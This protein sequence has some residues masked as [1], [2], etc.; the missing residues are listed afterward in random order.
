MRYDGMIRTSFGFEG[1]LLNEL[2]TVDDE[3]QVDALL[4]SVRLEN[5]L[6]LEIEG[7]PVGRVAL[8]QL[9]IR[10][11]RINLEIGA[12]IWA[13]YRN[14]LRNT[15]AALFAMKRLLE[16]H[17]PDRLVVYN[18]LYSVNR[19]AC[20]MAEARGVPAQFLHAGVNLSNRLQTLMLGRYDTFSYYPRLVEQWHRFADLPCEQK[21]LSLVT[22][23]YL[24][25]IGARTVFVYSKGLSA[26]PVA[27]RERFGVAM[28]QKLVVATLGSYDEEVAAE[29]VGAR[30]I[31]KP[32][33]FKTQVEWIETLL[34]F[35]ATRS[36]VFLLVRV[37]P[38][39]FPNRRDGKKSEHAEL[40]EKAL[41]R[42]PANVAVNWPSDDIS[43]YDLV[44]DADVFLNS[45][46]STGK[47]MALLGIPTVIYSDVLPL[48]P[49]E[50]NYFGDTER[51]YFAAIDAALSDGWNFEKVRQT[52]RWS[53]YEFVRSTLFIGDSFCEEEAPRRSILEK[54]NRRVQRLV[55]RDSHVRKH[56]KRYRPPQAAAQIV[57][58]VESAAM[59]VVDRIGSDMLKAASLKEETAALR[60]ELRRLADALFPDPKLRANSRL[61]GRLT[62][63]ESAQSAETMQ[64]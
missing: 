9:A 46:S 47:D 14:E 44:E 28:D 10:S 11:K 15:L 20:L 19:A 35:A 32:L 43:I 7:V 4:A 48:Y 33:L 59:T 31:T 39:E 63:T 23:H 8:Y 60:L 1:P 41:Q 18:G 30:K 37:H 64:A 5:V 3:R 26:E 25:L 56:L 42:L 52:Y 50:L 13:E 6:D 36:D 29:M 45:W 17:H 38:R 53:V 54:I 34:Q 58:I 24:H 22:N 16:T 57:D 49:T 61:Y 62:S 55:D 2:L 40:L 51:T 21:L 12:E 27:V